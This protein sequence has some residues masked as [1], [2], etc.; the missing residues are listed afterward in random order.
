MGSSWYGSTLGIVTFFNLYIMKF[1]H[2]GG[3]AEFLAIKRKLQAVL[4]DD[5]FNV[6]QGNTG[7]QYLLIYY[8]EPHLEL[9]CRL[10]M[11]I[12]ALLVQGDSFF[13]P[14]FVSIC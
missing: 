2:N 14:A 6:V 10:R 7:V 4:P 5:I 9:R 8:L 3:I 13:L 12:R 1:M 11:G